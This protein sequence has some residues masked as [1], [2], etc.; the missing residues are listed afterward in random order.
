MSKTE[1]GQSRFSFTFLRWARGK[2]QFDHPGGDVTQRGRGDLYVKFSGLHLG[3]VEYVVYHA[4]QP[5]RSPVHRNKHLALPFVDRTGHFLQKKFHKAPHR[6]HGIAQIVSYGVEELLLYP[7]KFPLQCYVVQG[8]DHSD[9]GLSVRSDDLQR[10]ALVNSLHL[11]R[12]H[13]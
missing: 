5:E 8:R 11:V 2:H 6:P 1:E 4:Q 12:G 3:D 10:G 7:C 9:A 13:L